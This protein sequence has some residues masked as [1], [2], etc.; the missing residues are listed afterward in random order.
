MYYRMLG[1]QIGVGARISPAA[2]LAEYDL[3][4]VGDGAAI[5]ISTVRAFGIDNGAMILGPVRVG[6][7]ASVGARSVVAPYT[8][9]P[10]NAHLGPISASYEISTIIENGNDAE[11]IRFNRQ[12]LPL[13]SACS[14]LFF[15]G[16]IMFLV[17]LFAQIPALTVLYL[18]LHQAWNYDRPF[19]STGHMLEWLCDLRRIP[20]FIGIRI[21]RSTLAPFF[22]MSMAIVLKWCVIGKFV[23]GPRDT[24]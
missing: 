21:A 2:E 6:N 12:A 23:P 17:N 8:S 16:P 19:Q 10:D 7:N 9:I 14:E 13:P 24:N 20:F 22:Y 1:A 5:E 11:N 18:M 3:V 4:T 15:V